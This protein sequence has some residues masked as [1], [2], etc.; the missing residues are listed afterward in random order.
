MM[1]ILLCLSLHGYQFA[2]FVPIWTLQ[3]QAELRR[4]NSELLVCDRSSPWEAGWVALSRSAT[5]H[6][7]WVCDI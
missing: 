2:D 3:V 7:C 5:V 6:A 4:I 1:C